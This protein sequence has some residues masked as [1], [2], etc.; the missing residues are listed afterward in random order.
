[1][2]VIY[3]WVDE[4]SETFFMSGE[5]LRDI[6]VYRRRTV[7]IDENGN[8]Y[9]MTETRKGNGDREVSFKPICR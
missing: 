6:E 9:E 4:P 7:F 2:K 5:D 3:D 8:K 1:M